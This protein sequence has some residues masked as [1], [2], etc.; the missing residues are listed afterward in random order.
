MMVDDYGAGQKSADPLFSVVDGGRQRRIVLFKNK[1]NVG[2]P[3]HLFRMILSIGSKHR[4]PQ[5]YPDVGEDPFIF[6]ENE[7][8]ETNLTHDI[9]TSM[10]LCS[11]SS[12][13]LVDKAQKLSGTGTRMILLPDGRRF[14]NPRS[15][16]IWWCGE[17][18][19]LMTLAVLPSRHSAK[20]LQIDALP[21]TFN[22]GPELE[23]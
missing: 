19:N 14:P 6:V 13:V 15:I 22:P 2:W 21:G 8:Y 4:D 17:G 16:N 23:G 12:Q 18:A 9:Y 5:G 3:W 10:T 20:L 11:S 1:V 7:L